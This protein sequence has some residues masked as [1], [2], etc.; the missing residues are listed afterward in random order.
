VYIGF[1]VAMHASERVQIFGRK[2]RRRGFDGA[3]RT[4]V[5]TQRAYSRRPSVT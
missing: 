4:R 2:K 3:Q 5:A 1:N